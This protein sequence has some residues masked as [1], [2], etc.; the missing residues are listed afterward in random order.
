MP[1]VSW[2]NILTGMVPLA[3]VIEKTGPR[4][5]ESALAL[6]IALLNILLQISWLA[7]A[8]MII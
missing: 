6:F 8:Y 7:Q 4:R 2:A 3:L 1:A 5:A